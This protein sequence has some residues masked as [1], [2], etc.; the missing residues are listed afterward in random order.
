MAS[1]GQRWS[2]LLNIAEMFALPIHTLRMKER[3]FQ[4][5]LVFYKFKGIHCSVISS[6]EWG[7]LHVGEIST[8]IIFEECRDAAIKKKRIN[9]IG[10]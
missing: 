4:T 7:W 1:N 3:H 10:E 2:I 5:I 9:G 6:P 8:F